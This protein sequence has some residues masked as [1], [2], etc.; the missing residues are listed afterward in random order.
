MTVLNEGANPGGVGVLKYARKT[1]TFTGAAGFGLAGDTITIWT[2]TGSIWIRALIPICTVTL[3][4]NL[5]TPTLSLGRA[6]SVA[7]LIAATTATGIT[8]V[9][10]I[11]QDATAT[12]AYEVQTAALKDFIYASNA[13]D[14]SAKVGG[15]NNIDGGTLVFHCFYQPLTDGANL[16]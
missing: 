16:A 14:I 8:S 1:L 11:W 15:T 7:E 9:N 4:Q 5:G 3:T 6:A 10:N 2:L 13:L 12:P